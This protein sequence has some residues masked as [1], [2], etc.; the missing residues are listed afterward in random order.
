MDDG[1]SFWAL[2]GVPAI[3]HGPRAAGQHTVNEWISIDDMERVAL[4]YASK[5]VAYCGQN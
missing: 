5:A 4:L 2:A 1:N 3:T